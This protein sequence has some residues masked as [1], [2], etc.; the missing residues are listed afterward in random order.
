MR[1]RTR[2][3]FW[4]AMVLL[5]AWPALWNGGPFFFPDSSHYIRSADAAVVSLTG[6]KSEW[7]D[8]IVLFEDEQLKP[9]AHEGKNLN[10]I[11]IRS[12]RT[13]LTGRS[14]YYGGM[15]YI[16]LMAG[17]LGP[18]FIQS[19]IAVTAIGLFL[20]GAARGV[21]PRHRKRWVWGGLLAVGALT[22]L[23]FFVSRLMPDAF[24]GLLAVALVALLVFWDTYTKV[25]RAVLILIASAAILFH[26]SHILLT[27]AIGAAALMLN[28]GANASWRRLIAL[29]LGL[30]LV[31][32]AGQ[33]IFSAGVERTLNTSPISPPFMSARLIADGP[34]YQY[35][36]EHCGT[37]AFMLC[38]YMD[39]MPQGSDTLLWS[40]DP[41]EGI[42]S[43]VADPVKRAL[44]EQDVAFYITVLKARPIEVLSSMLRSTA[45]QSVAF[46]LSH[47]NYIAVH[48]EGY[49]LHLPE[50]TF[51]S[52][53]RSA[54][55][56]GTVPV[57]PV[58]V[59]TI[60]MTF[61]S[62]IVIGVAVALAVRQK[63]WPLPA[64]TAAMLLVL[65]V[66]A[67]IVI[68]G[69]LSTPHGRY[70][71]RIIWLLPLAVAALGASGFQFRYPR[72]IPTGELAKP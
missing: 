35:L 14:V 33:M 69:A 21:D 19:A 27:I 55:F 61:A 60:V 63:A 70:L 16:G 49:R 3:G 38:H 28:V 42:F 22:P 48:R 32:A 9:S 30:I 12:T 66:A 1:V 54:A 13:V 68:C 46:R 50:A 52:V 7:S 51:R 10:P 53:E 64:V 5:Y 37:E 24:T 67:N 36:K 72:R 31:S 8:R 65:A 71:M 6:V 20:C 45:K 57:Y 4:V 56:R 11:S 15:L 25:A 2:V 58:Q 43:T 41:R 39:R 23:P 59:L 47:F 17:A 62:C 18:V 26:T 44:G 40:E 29:P 34:G